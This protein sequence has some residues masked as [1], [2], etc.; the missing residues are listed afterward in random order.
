MRCTKCSDIHIQRL[1][2]LAQDEFEGCSVPVSSYY[3]HYESLQDLEASAE[4]GCDMCRLIVRAFSDAT[5]SLDYYEEEQSLL[6]AIKGWE[7]PALIH[8][9][10]EASHVYVGASLDEVHNF[11]L[12]QV[13]ARTAKDLVEA[14]DDPWSTWSSDH[15][16]HLML[17]TR[18]GWSLEPLESTANCLQIL[19]TVLSN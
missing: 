9:A 7:D 14:S 15:S 4:S 12:L 18:R 17:S 1:I 19:Q 10:I 13:C 8:M 5:A 6:T 11:D 16:V 3:Q 2:E